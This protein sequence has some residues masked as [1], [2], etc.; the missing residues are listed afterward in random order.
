MERKPCRTTAGI[1]YTA[2]SIAG[3]WN[4]LLTVTPLKYKK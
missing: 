2:V 4:T 3:D 1:Y